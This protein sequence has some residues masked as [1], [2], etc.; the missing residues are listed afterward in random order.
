MLKNALTGDYRSFDV[1]KINYTELIR[2][3]MLDT[4]ESFNERYLIPW[5]C[6]YGDEKAIKQK[7]LFC[8]NQ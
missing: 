2:T 7:M 3:W 8:W 1:I 6:N 5:Y 4:G